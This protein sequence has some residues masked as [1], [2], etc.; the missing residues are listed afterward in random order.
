LSHSAAAAAEPGVRREGRRMVIAE[1]ER[2]FLRHFHVAD[3]D[4]MAEV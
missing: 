2:V 4:A 3:L 1:T